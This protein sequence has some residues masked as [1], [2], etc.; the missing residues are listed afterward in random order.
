MNRMY[1]MTA[2]LGVTFIFAAR[3]F[4]RVL[5]DA[6][7]DRHLIERDQSSDNNKPEEDYGTIVAPTA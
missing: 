4:R 7:S 1:P 5:N 3:Q 6:L 2:L